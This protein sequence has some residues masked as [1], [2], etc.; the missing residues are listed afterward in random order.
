MGE[1]GVWCVGTCWGLMVLPMFLPSAHLARMLI[2]SL[3]VWGEHF[4][5]P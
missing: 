2:A 5:P 3:L 1:H 4:N